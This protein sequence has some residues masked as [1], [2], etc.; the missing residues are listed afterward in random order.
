GKF[1]VA[2][3]FLRTNLV[4]VRSDRTVD[5]NW[6]PIMTGGGVYTMLLTNGTLYVGGGFTNANGQARN[7]LA[8]VDSVTGALKPWNPNA[9][10]SVR[11]MALNSTNLYIGG[12]FTTL[13]GQ[14]RNRIAAVDL[15]A[16][17]PTAW[18]PGAGDW[19]YA[20]T[21]SAG[22]LYVGGYFTSM[23]SQSRGYA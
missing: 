18:N 9:G 3:G 12:E 8:A 13:G 10:A 21:I 7:R 5:P 15:I 23:N 1:N 6:S 19:V 16:G 4:H 17:Q 22:H 11:T 14:T 2:G 20:M